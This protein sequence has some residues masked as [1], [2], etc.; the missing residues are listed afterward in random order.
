MQHEDPAWAGKA[1]LLQRSGE[2]LCTLGSCSSAEVMAA[3]AE[4][5]PGCGVSVVDNSTTVYLYLK[6]FLDPRK[7]LEKLGK[8][9]VRLMLAVLG[10]R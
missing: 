2:E 7:E 9:L 1:E 10:V 4:A 6:D 5:P 3:G 8:D